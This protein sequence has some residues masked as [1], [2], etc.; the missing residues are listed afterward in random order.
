MTSVVKALAVCGPTASGKSALGIALA[1]ALNGEVVNVDSVQVY[2]D[3]DIGSA[4]VTMDEREGIAHHLLDL[5]PPNYQMNAGEYRELA[6]PCVKEIEGRGKMPVLVGGSGMYLTVLLH[7]MADVPP[8]PLDVRAA[9]AALSREDQYAELQ[10]VD[11]PTAARLHVNDTQR[12]SRALEIYRITGKPPSAI[13][14]EHKFA[15]QDV[16]ALMIVLCRE[17]DELYERI[18]KRS[19]IMVEQGLL[20]ETKKLLDTYGEIPVLETIGYKQARDVLSG[21]LPV[22]ELAKEISLHTRRFAKRQMT[23][24]RNEPLK[25]GWAVRPREDEAAQEVLGFSGA[26]KRAQEKVKGFRALSMSEA[27]IIEAV[28]DRCKAPLV[29]SEVWYVYPTEGVRKTV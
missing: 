3:V 4:K 28:R 10:R 13:F 6:L 22:G 14:E 25:R 11:P 15:S 16:A 12:V 21:K 18:N 5:F 7:G 24:L 2:R 17:R 29:R 20:D 23:Y 1:K 8:T 27:E 19:Q 9:V 26:S